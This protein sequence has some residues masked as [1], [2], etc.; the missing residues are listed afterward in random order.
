MKFF[1]KKTCGIALSL[2]F[3]GV[4][5][6]ATAALAADFKFQTPWPKSPMGTDIMADANPSLAKAIQYLYEW[7]IGLGGMAVFV[8]LIIA[9]FEYITSI[10]NPSKMQDA[11]NR[12]RDAVVGLIVLLSSYAI[13]TMIGINLSGMKIDMPDFKFES[14][15]STCASTEGSSAPDCCKIK[16][17]VSTSWNCTDG[18][19]ARAN[20]GTGSGASGRT[21]SNQADC[22]IR[23]GCDESFYTCI[24]YDNTVTPAKPGSCKPNDKKTDCAEAKIKFTPATVNGNSTDMSLGTG[25]FDKQQR[26]LGSV[27]IESMELYYDDNG[28]HR[29]CYDPTSSNPAAREVKNKVC[30]C[31]LQ[32]FTKSST[33]G[34]GGI[35]EA[36]G[37]T[38]PCE[39][40]EVQFA[41]DNNS[42]KNYSKTKDIRCIMLS[43]NPG[44]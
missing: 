7:G 20:G 1:S 40:S 36:V 21:C 19:C 14:P 28:T 6:F 37:L 44:I 17:C 43:K 42:L 9:G 27:K 33:S 24:G 39:N 35:L 38:N 31:G 25:D 23:T 11:F 12:I 2:A 3:A 15:I 26:I 41:N 32:L 5:G 22:C 30:N 16:G 29:P 8:A 18:K 4:L 34:G 13:L 10:G